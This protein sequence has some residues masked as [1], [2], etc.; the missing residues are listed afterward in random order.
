MTPSQAAVLF[1]PG[2]TEPSLSRD[3]LR[4]LPGESLYPGIAHRFESADLY[5][6]LQ[7]TSYF[8]F[9][10]FLLCRKHK[11]HA[12]TPSIKNIFPGYLPCFQDK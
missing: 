6:I 2:N 11:I 8:L 1:R 4:K 10:G 3:F 7:E 9:E 5:L 12:F